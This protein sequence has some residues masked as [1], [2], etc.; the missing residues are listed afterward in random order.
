MVVELGN[1]Y[2]RDLLRQ[3]HLLC[4]NHLAFLKRTLH[5]HI[6]KLVAEIDGLLDQRDEAP[7]DF[8]CDSSTLLNGLEQSAARLNSEC[9]TTITKRC[10]YIIFA[11]SP[12]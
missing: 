11:L 3:V 6:L 2:R 12:W 8:Q 9:L 1:T 7:F 5:V 10:Q 4:Q